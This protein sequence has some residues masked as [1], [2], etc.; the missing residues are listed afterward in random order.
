METSVI[1]TPNPYGFGRNWSLLVKTPGHTKSFY[2]GQDVK[3]CSRV[4]GMTPRDVVE[5]IGTG[6]ISEG[7][8]GNK[9][10]AEFICECLELDE[11]NVMG[12]ESWSLSAE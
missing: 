3:F 6:E 10:L 2:L 8:P 5:A 7:Q 12:L 1:I 11:T 4:L 9:K